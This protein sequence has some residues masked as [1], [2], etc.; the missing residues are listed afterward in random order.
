MSIHIFKKKYKN[1]SEEEVNA[2][3][4]SNKTE[5]IRKITKINNV[6][7]YLDKYEMFKERYQGRTET[8]KKY[9]EYKKNCEKIK[10]SLLK[11]KICR[12]VYSGYKCKFEDK[13]F[14]AH[15]RSEQVMVR[16][17]FYKN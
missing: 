4:N 17:N 2:I 15:S 12:S 5:V 3:L 8:Y 10:R 7:A 14:F 16:N 1:L 13:C 11:T 9:E 6:K